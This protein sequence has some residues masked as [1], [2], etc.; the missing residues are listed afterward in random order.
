MSRNDCCMTKWQ[1]N[2]HFYATFSN[3]IPNWATFREKIVDLIFTLE[4]NKMT[5]LWPNDSATFTFYAT[6]LSSIPNR[7]TFM[8]IIFFIWCLVQKLTKWLLCDQM[9]VSLSLFIWL[10]QKAYQIEQLLWEK[11]FDLMISS[12]RDEMTAVWLNDS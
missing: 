1:L 9:T 7:A 10:S 3:Y 5:A 11:F 12:E 4:S 6:F 8:K 2:S